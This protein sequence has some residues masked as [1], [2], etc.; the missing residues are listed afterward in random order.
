VECSTLPPDHEISRLGNSIEHFDQ[1]PSSCRPVIGE[2]AERKRG[3]NVETANHGWFSR[4]C[5]LT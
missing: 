2:V 5:A 1:D 4:E 3:V